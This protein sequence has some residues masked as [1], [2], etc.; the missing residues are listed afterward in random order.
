VGATGQSQYSAVAEM[1]A[2]RVKS[3]RGSMLRPP[4]NYHGQRHFERLES[5]DLARR[6]SA[7][8]KRRNESIDRS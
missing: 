7:R 2:A 4:K 8:P 6:L 5:P 3:R 1:L